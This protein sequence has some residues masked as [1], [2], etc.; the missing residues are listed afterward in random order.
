MSP[1][2]TELFKALESAPDAAVEQTFEYLKSILLAKSYVDASNTADHQ[3]SLWLDRLH[4]NRAKL[5]V[6]S[7]Q[8][9]VIEMRQEERY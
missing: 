5:S 4:Q 3:R 9:T 8:Q 7:T 1:I 2:K 6:S